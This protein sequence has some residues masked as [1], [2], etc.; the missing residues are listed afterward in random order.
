M[1]EVLVPFTEFE[2]AVELARQL[3]EVVTNNIP[4]LEAR[5][6]LGPISRY[7]SND[8]I[9]AQEKVEK[10]QREHQAGTLGHYAVVGDSG[11]VV[12][13]ASIYPDL[14]LYKLRL[15][16]PAGIA[17]RAEPFLAVR[18]SYASPNIHAWADDSEDVLAQTYEEL[19][20]LANTPPSYHPLSGTPYA[21]EP[22][23]TTWTLEPAR[24]PKYIHDAI[25]ASSG[26][27]RVAKRRFDDGED[28]R[29]I[30][31]RGT[32]YAQLKSTWGT[33][34]GMQKEL[35]TGRHSFMARMDQSI[36]E[37]AGQSITG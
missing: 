15:P 12:G 33:A 18:Y 24:S 8:S 5:N 23:N 22:F 30:P 29:T 32:L 9:R 17:R 26:L 2:S 11:D 1:S 25:V 4:M 13:S 37:Q 36:D 21:K 35:R 20:Q 16:V 14:P 19:T 10:G 7:G 27:Q 28:G 31:P 6:L 3:H 34:H